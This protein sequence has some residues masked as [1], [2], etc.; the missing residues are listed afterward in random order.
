MPDLNE[1]HFSGESDITSEKMK[2]LT[3]KGNIKAVSETLTKLGW[4]GQQIATV[5]LRI[6]TDG[7]RVED[8]QF[9]LRGALGKDLV[10]VQASKLW[11]KADE[12]VWLEIIT[13][14]GEWFNFEGRRL[15][16]EYLDQERV[17][18]RVTKEGRI[19]SEAEKKDNGVGNFSLCAITH[20]SKTSNNAS[21]PHIKYTILVHHLGADN[22]ADLREA[23]QSPSW[24]GIKML[25]GQ[26]Q[27]AG[28]GRFMGAPM[29]AATAEHGGEGRE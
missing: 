19:L 23:T 29:H 16:S 10:K 12:N 6:S 11:S 9:N 20:L 15:F 28:S 25:E 2:E 5:T 17:N 8:G 4:E 21:G 7:G 18:Y 22:I 26:C 24:P 13:P 3:T 27:P 1:K 14:P